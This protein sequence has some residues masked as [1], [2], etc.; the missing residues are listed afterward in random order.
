MTELMDE[1]TERH[2]TAEPAAELSARRQSLNP[3]GSAGMRRGWL[4]RLPRRPGG[5]EHL[6]CG[7]ESCQPFQAQDLR[8]VSAPPGHNPALLTS[9]HQVRGPDS[10]SRGASGPVLTHV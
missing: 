10:P 2:V 8:E 7:Q 3:T 9:T 6:L 5:R 4:G 1:K